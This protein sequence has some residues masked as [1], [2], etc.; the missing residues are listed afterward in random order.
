M[1]RFVRAFV[2]ALLACA[3]ALPAQAQ[4]LIIPLTGHR[5]RPIQTETLFH[6]LFSDFYSESDHTTYVQT[7][8][9]PAMWL[10]DS[11]AQTLP[12]VRFS[13]AYPILSV[14]FAGVIERNAKNIA[15]DPYANAFRPDYGVWERKWEAGSLAWPIV[16]AWVYRQQTQQRMLYT[17]ALHRALR[18][19]VDT[20][21]CEQLHAQCSRYTFPGVDLR[22][23][24]N[25]ETGM[26]WSAF[27]PSDDR[28]KYPF[29]IPQ[30]MLV[31]VALQDAARLAV[32]GYGDRDLAN[33]AH[34]MA[35]QVA[36]GIM[37]YG[38]VWNSSYGGWMYVYE[39]DGLGHDLY[40]DDAN[41]PNLTSAPYLG[42]SSAYDSAYLN[43]RA[44]TLSP[45]NP[46]YFRG[47]YAEGLGSP[48][49]PDG[50]VWPLGV[51][52]RALTATSASETAASITMLAETDSNDGLIHESFWPDGYWLFTRAYF[53]W[54]NALYAEL[55]FRSVAGFPGTDFTAY[56]MPVL[57]RETLSSTPVLTSKLVQ[58]RDTGLVYQALGD[59][60]A[61]AN[62]HTII[63][64]IEQYMQSTAGSDG[65]DFHEVQDR[66]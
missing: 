27:R 3:L 48:H 59:L 56:G 29:N 66:R 65:P 30:E 18:K 8:D 40:M 37:R 1:I 52:A 50:F 6:T 61:R 19:A 5:I 36:L 33:E 24:Y 57:A 13:N 17:G 39:T 35:S 21:R 41:V 60:L 20:W 46:Y 14:R 54:A 42:W 45:R 7:G 43:T 2:C 11:S 58:I 44:Y 28:V 53:G 31:V 49:T 4:P 12:Y 55:L 64:N 47:A 62:G 63:P 51:I 25:T 26:I 15:V 9:I 38:C 16:L 34:S 22:M 23:P 32:D 10:R